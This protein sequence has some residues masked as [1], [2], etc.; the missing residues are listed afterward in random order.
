VIR[1]RRAVGL[2]DDPGI[3]AVTKA[4]FSHGEWRALDSADAVWVATAYHGQILGYACV[5]GIA[6]QATAYLSLSAVEPASRGQ[7]IQRRLILAR[8]RWARE[9]HFAWAITYTAEKNLASAN[10]LIKAGFKLY[11]PA[12]PWGLPHAMYWR[13]RL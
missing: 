8:L 11:L 13:R 3:E 9:N 6:S 4:C 10:S 5:R 12:E 7:G 1:I 2:D